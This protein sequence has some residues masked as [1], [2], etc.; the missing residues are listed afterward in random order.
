MSKIQ[1]TNLILGH[2]DG[3]DAFKAFA[4]ARGCEIDLQAD[5]IEI[6]S[7][8]SDMWKEFIAGR[9]EWSMTCECLLA[10][11][12]SEIEGIF[13]AREPIKVSC[14]LRD[15]SGYRHTGNAIINSLKLSGRLHEMASYT[16]GLKGTGPLD[17]VAT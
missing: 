13:R 6:A 4:Y 11:D 3:N 10:K 7:P 1:G 5:M 12:E 14:R 2:H 17:Y 8:S 9:C 15:G 16:I